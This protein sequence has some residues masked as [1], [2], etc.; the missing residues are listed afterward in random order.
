[1]QV[2]F[3]HRGTE[4]PLLFAPLAFHVQP[5]PRHPHTHFPIPTPS[6]RIST[7]TLLGCYKVRFLRCWLLARSFLDSPGS[8]EIVPFP[9]SAPRGSPWDRGGLH[10]PTLR[11][12]VRFAFCLLFLFSFFRQSGM[13]C[14]FPLL[15]WV[16]QLA[17]AFLAFVKEKANSTC[18][19]PG[20]PIGP[21][22]VPSPSPTPPADAAVCPL[23]LGGDRCAGRWRGVK[24]R[25]EL[26]WQSGVGTALE[27]S[28]WGEARGRCPH[29]RRASG[30]CLVPAVFYKGRCCHPL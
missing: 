21:H 25:E 26:P 14:H 23:A 11:S 22:R 1:M 28:R 29:R 27:R 4:F 10:R 17:F 16:L 20:G 9:P 3:A 6:S 5:V 13:S 8:W 30:L 18:F 7:L 12:S 24:A 15:S 19:F 2:A